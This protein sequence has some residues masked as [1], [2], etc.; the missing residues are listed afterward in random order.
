MWLREVCKIVSQLVKIISIVSRCSL[1]K[2]SGRNNDAHRRGADNAMTSVL[3]AGDVLWRDMFG[4]DGGSGSMHP[5][6]QAGSG[7]PY[8]KWRHSQTRRSRCPCTSRS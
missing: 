7:N 6:S 8:V 2:N 5:V 3:Y 1:Q 4:I